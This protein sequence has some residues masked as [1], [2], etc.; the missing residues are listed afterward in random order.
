MGFVVGLVGLLF[1]AAASAGVIGGGPHSA[2]A[3]DN[4]SLR[5]DRYDVRLD[6]FDT[7]ANQF[8]VTEDYELY[9]ERGPYSYGFAEIPM[10]RLNSITDVSVAQDGFALRA[11]CG[12]VQGTFCAS[13]SGDTYSITYYFRQSADSGETVNIQIGYT[14]TGALRS[15]E[16]GDQLWWVAVPGD[17][18]FPVRASTITVELPADRPPQV[19]TSYP[20]FPVE[21]E[22]SSVTWTVNRTLRGG[23]E[24]EVRVQYPHDPAMAKPGWQTGFDFRQDYEEKYQPFVSALLAALGVLIAL[25]GG[26]FVV[27]RFLSHGRDPESLAVPEYLTEPPSDARPGVVGT[28]L[29]EGADMQDIM[30]TLMDLARRGYLVIEQG[31]TGGLA[32]L[33]SGPK[34]TFHRT[35]KPATDLLDFEEGLLRGIFPRGRDTTDLADL[36]AKFYTHIPAIKHQLYGQLVQRGY[37]T[38]SPE[39]TRQI[40]TWGGIAVVVVAG[41]LFW[42]GLAAASTVSWACAVPPVGL[43]IAGLAAAIAGHSMP[44][45]TQQGAQEAA[46]WRAFRTYLRH[47]ERYTDLEAAAAKFED[48]IGYAVAFGMEQQWIRQLSPVLTA[49]PTWYFPTYLGGP[50]R[51]GYQRG[52]YQPGGMGRGS[53]MGDISLGGP[54]GLNDISGSL[55]AGLNAMSGG[56]TRMLN[57]A[58]SVMSS[59]PQSSSGGGG[60]SGGGSHGGGGS[61]GGSRGFG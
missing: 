7:S 31:E 11:A 60:F 5:W 40:W 19:W 44:A 4:R 20:Q 21:V 57:D 17:R 56:M 58:S 13:S 59:R 12:Q 9:V 38:R 47:V 33:F 41:V 22:G 52:P 36:K 34:F 29:D 49:M 37:F 6:S 48:Y 39:T 25:A 18:S 2:T 10:D 30:G 3:Q 26:L 14:V 32:G 42:L 27:T 61:G 54:G 45:K 8:R 24:V 50:W 15:Y 23:D 46:R 43:G 28:L 55:T 1:A 16:K 51:G 53:G 35:E